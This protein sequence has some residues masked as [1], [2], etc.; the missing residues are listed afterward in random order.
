MDRL[1]WAP[2]PTICVVVS[3]L[4]RHGS[5]E[6]ISRRRVCVPALRRSLPLLRCFNRCGIPGRRIICRISG[7]A[8]AHRENASRVECMGENLKESWLKGGRG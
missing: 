7:T 3:G 2:D 8:A 1:G 6:R 4:E 5:A